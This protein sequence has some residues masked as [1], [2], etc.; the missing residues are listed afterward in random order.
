V[1]CYAG[2]LAGLVQATR[3]WQRQPPAA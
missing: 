3:L 1:A 2:T